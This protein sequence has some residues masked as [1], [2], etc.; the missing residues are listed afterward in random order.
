MKPPVMRQRIL[1]LLLGCL[2]ML[3][4]PI[5]AEQQASQT[6]RGTGA[7]TWIGRYQEVEEYLRTAECVKLEDLD[8]GASGLQRCTLRPG[9]PVLRMAWRSLPP[10]IYR[11]FKE[12]YKAEIAAYELDKLLKLDMV[13]PA[14]ERETQGHKG[15]AVQWVENVVEWKTGTSPGESDRIHWEG[16]LN[17]MAMFDNLIGNRARSRGN[18]LHDAAWNLVL[19]D[20]TRAF[21]AETELPNVLRRIDENLWTKI[22]TLSRNQLDAAMRPWLDERQVEA[23]LDRREKMKADVVRLRPK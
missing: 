20:H 13:P 8:P 16:Q 7:K 4:V 22:E 2:L 6:P 11:G 10:G 23:I 14:V 18:S 3:L 17:R 15:S 5:T 9:G 12:S 1:V 19:I 21:Y